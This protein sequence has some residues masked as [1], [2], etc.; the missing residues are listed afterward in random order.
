MESINY[1]SVSKD[2][3]SFFIGTNMG[4]KIFSTATQKLVSSHSK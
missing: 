4:Y 2:K 1:I 3:E